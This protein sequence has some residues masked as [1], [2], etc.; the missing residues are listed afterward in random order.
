MRVSKFFDKDFFGGTVKNDNISN[1]ELLQGINK[2]IIR[3]LNKTKVHSS[4]IDNIRYAGL[5]DMQWINKFN[6]GFRFLL[7][8]IDIYGKYECYSFKRW[9]MN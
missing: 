6:R 2:P 8:V 1:K 9:T 7:C 5:A 3:K 4:F